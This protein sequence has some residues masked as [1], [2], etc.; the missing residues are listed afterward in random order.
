MLGSE[1]QP[2]SSTPKDM[3]GSLYVSTID[4][5]SLA[6]FDA[7]TES[8]HSLGFSTTNFEYNAPFV[9]LGRREIIGLQAIQNYFKLIPGVD[10]MDRHCD[11][12]SNCD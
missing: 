1:L 7:I 2:L 3:E 4:V 10:R 8:G 11:D 5:E 6:L 9:R 12:R